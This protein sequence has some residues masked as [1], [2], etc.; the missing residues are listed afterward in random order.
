MKNIK[1]RQQRAKWCKLVCMING[2]QQRQMIDAADMLLNARRMN[3]PIVDLPPELRPETLEE[4]YFVQDRMSLAY[5][6]IG[7]WK[8]GAPS[9]DAFLLAQRLLV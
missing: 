8:V 9:A 6:A 7:G 4:A 3:Q 2:A 5:E 1:T